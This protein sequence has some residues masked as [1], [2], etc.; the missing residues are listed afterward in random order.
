[1]MSLA[2]LLVADFKGVCHHLPLVSSLSFV[3]HNFVT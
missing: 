1:M 2:P 3:L